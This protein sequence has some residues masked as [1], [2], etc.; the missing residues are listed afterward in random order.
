MTQHLWRA[1]S[2]GERFL[3]GE[4]E[5]LLADPTFDPLTL[6]VI[7]YRLAR[8]GRIGEL[9]RAGAHERLLAMAPT[10]PDTFIIH[11]LIHPPTAEGWAARQP[12]LERAIE[13]GLPLVSDGHVILDEW[14]TREAKAGRPA[15]AVPIRRPVN[16]GALAVFDGTEGA[17]ALD[18]SRLPHHVLAITNEA[19]LMGGLNEHGRAVELM[20]E[21]AN[22]VRD[23]AERRP[24]AF[25]PDLARVLSD[26]GVRLGLAGETHDAL[27]VTREAVFINEALRDRYPGRFEAELAMSVDNLS[28]RLRAVGRADESVERAR[29]AA[30]LFAGLVNAGED[31]YRVSLAKSL[32]NLGV[33]LAAV[34]EIDEALDV[35]AEAV[36]WLRELE[37]EHPLR[38]AEEL[39]VATQSMAARLLSLGRPEEARP[40]ALEALEQFELLAS[41]SPHVKVRLAASHNNLAAILGQMNDVANAVPHAAKATK[42]YEELHRNAPT[43]FAKSWAHSLRNFAKLLSLAGEADSAAATTGVAAM[44]LRE[45][46][47]RRPEEFDRDLDEALKDH[48]DLLGE[49]PAEPLVTKAIDQLRRWRGMPGDTD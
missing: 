29:E 26:L 46:F 14:A 21:A 36:H 12:W 42:L 22:Q 8:E 18:G 13:A 49:R 33:G 47:E 2:A 10:L 25:E 44:M 43:A 48:L 20:R 38:Y 19:H 45:E 7:G 6:A 39:A 15:P 30:T 5:R 3:S 9:V 28:L 37:H 31:T 24:D 17:A 1:L 27:E 40:Y 11:A 41:E 32:N 16:E 34:D 35:T 4:A 23:L